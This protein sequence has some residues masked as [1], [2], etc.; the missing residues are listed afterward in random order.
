MSNNKVVI[1]DGRFQPYTIDNPLATAMANEAGAITVQNP[2]PTGIVGPDGQ[3]AT[4]GSNGSLDVNISDQHS[5]I[6]DLHLTKIIT[7]ITL[8]NSVTRGSSVA[9]VTTTGIAPVIGNV[10]CFKEGTA[11]YQG[12]VLTV[13]LVSGNTYDITLDTP[14]DYPYTVLGGCSLRTQNMNV[15]GSV[16]PQIFSVS[17][18]NLVAGTRWDIVRIMFVIESGTSMDE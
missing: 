11:F 9:R 8:V 3:Q 6:I 17:P 14:F 13:T 15:N 10:A 12:E 16:T 5:E 7:T 1:L 18:K 4:V 2:L